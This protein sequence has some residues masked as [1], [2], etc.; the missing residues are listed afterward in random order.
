[1]SAS[2]MEDINKD[3]V[4]NITPLE[5]TNIKNENEES[6][7]ES[8]TEVKQES[9]DEIQ[10]N[11]F[12]GVHEGNIAYNEDF[13]AIRTEVKQKEMIDTSSSN[14]LFQYNQSEVNSSIYESADGEK[15]DFVFNIIPCGDDELISANRNIE[16]KDESQH[17]VCLCIQP[18]VSSII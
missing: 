11:I 6:A 2:K 9:S 1:M 17:Q 8:K 5:E 13:D 10:C 14:K 12:A 18:I 3:Q 7:I 4:N 16:I 15:P